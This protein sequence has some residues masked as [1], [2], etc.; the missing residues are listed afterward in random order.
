MGYFLYLLVGGWETMIFECV[1]L[2]GKLRKFHYCRIVASLLFFIILWL[3]SFNNMGILLWTW[4]VHIWIPKTES[5]L[6]VAHIWR[7]RAGR[8]WLR[9]RLL[10]VRNFITT[11]GNR[12]GHR[13]P[14]A[15]QRPRRPAVRSP[16]TPTDALKGLQL[17][18]N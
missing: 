6:F 9:G 1:V 3:S 7:W 10:L 18:P 13:P 8:Y 17:R 5:Q 2:G 15:T 11:P 12:K 4:T 14:P 16:P